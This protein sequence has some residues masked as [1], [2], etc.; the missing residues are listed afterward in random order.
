[1]VIHGEQL[2]SI[3]DEFIGISFKLN[4]NLIPINLKEL[5]WIQENS[6]EFKRL[7]EN[8]NESKRIL[9]NSKELDEI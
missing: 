7:Q 4:F 8:S 3:S 9:K 2:F 1:M 6:N 5:T